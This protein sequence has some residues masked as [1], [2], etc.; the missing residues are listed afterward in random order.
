MSI[1][2]ERRY[3]LASESDRGIF[4][5][6]FLSC[7]QELSHYILIVTRIQENETNRY[8]DGYIQT[9]I[10]RH[11]D[12]KYIDIQIHDTEMHHA[13]IDR[14]TGSSFQIFLVN[15]QTRVITSPQRDHL[16]SF[17]AN[18]EVSKISSSY[19]YIQSFHSS[20][21]ESLHLPLNDEVAFSP[22]QPI[23]SVSNKLL[24]L[25]QITL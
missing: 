3:I 7:T 25:C 17:L 12:D 11:I 1:S 18:E 13:Y 19:T 24:Q 23:H 8:I 21:R 9:Q 20:P 4:F 2:F 14:Y 15:N 5:S 6:E 16:I 10:L 22:G